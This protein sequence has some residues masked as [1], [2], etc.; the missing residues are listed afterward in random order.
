MYKHILLTVDGSDNALRAAEHAI[1]LAKL[2]EAKVD[3]INVIDFD[4]ARSEMIQTSD[5]E[6]TELR[7]LRYQPTVD[8]LI[9]NEIEH[10]VFVFHGNPGL[11]IVEHANDIDYDLIL[12]GSRGLNSLQEMFLG[13]VSHKVIQRANCPVL[14]VK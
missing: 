5:S 12:V 9:E 13:S 14:V 11:V 4:E 10:E 8:L 3:L 6:L 7:R 1:Q 2:T